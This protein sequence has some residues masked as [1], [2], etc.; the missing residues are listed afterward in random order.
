MSNG[1]RARVLVIDNDAQVGED[2]IEILTPYELAV[3]FLCTDGLERQDALLDT[4]AAYTRRFRPHVAVVDARLLNDYDP[5]ARS[6]FAVLT[7]LKSAQCILYSAHLDNKLTRQARQ[8]NVADW[9][10]KASSPDDLVQAVI[11]AAHRQSPRVSA[12]TIRWPAGWDAPR[13]LRNLT[14]DEHNDAPE[15][16]LDDVVAQLAVNRNV[17]ELEIM[18]RGEAA[19]PAA[20]R[21]R[22]AVML[23]QVDDLARNVLKLAKAGRAHKEIENYDAYVRQRLSGGFH[24][25]LLDHA[26]FWDVG[27]SL[28]SLMGTTQRL[29]PTFSDFYRDNTQQP[30][31]I[32]RPLRH[33]FTEVWAQHY[34]AGRTLAPLP[35]FAFYNSTFDLESKIAGL[36]SEQEK[37]LS[38]LTTEEISQLSRL[39]PAARARGKETSGCQAVTHG[40]FHGDNIFTDGAHLWVIDFERTGT[41]HALL[42]FVEL[43]VDIL[44]RLTDLGNAEDDGGDAFIEHYLRIEAGDFQAQ[45]GPNQPDA[46]KSLQVVMGIRQLARQMCHFTDEEYRL[47]VLY[48]AM[49]VAAIGRIPR[50]QR[51]RALH[52]CGALARALDL[53]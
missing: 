52:L 22:S 3:E 45:P 48:D 37:R 36:V 29:L 30:Q 38:P 47:G 50:R 13:L 21:G 9:I 25:E 51:Q 2:L 23:V 6:V 14:E 19:L 33:F 35:L 26:I 1:E 5:D 17:V 49:Y 15:T 43:E 12:M 53:G 11:T 40:D 27:A 24:T 4:V 34:T 31:D 16:L 28:Y 42:D 10:S 7:D 18:D 20:S 46:Q 8:S 44:T 41:H 39:L 32:L